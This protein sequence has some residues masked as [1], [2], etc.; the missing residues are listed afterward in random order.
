MGD[1]TNNSEAQFSRIL[2]HPF[3]QPHMGTDAPE[4]DR[5]AGRLR[6]PEREGETR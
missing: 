6:E 1:S 5:E 2:C 3:K 4:R